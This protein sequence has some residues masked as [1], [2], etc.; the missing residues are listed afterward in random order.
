[1]SYWSWLFY[2]SLNRQWNNVILTENNQR[3][4]THKIINN[5]K[6]NKNKTG[7]GTM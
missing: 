2:E 3:P 1:M 7:S 6:N 4:M 5:N